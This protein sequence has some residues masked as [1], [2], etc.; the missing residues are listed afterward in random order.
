VARSITPVVG[1]G[2]WYNLQGC[3]GK[4]G[5]VQANLWRPGAP[6]PLENQTDPRKEEKEKKKAGRQDGDRTLQWDGKATAPRA[7]W[8]VQEEE[9]SGAGEEEIESCKK[10]SKVSEKA[11]GMFTF[12]R[13][14]R[15][16]KG[17]LK[18]EGGK[19]VTDQ[20]E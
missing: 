12:G 8:G 3:H 13:E 17:I 6:E 10:Q 5:G 18:R 11:G 9:R 4:V 19:L 16:K 2:N 14:P 7:S 15:K 20:T 1:K